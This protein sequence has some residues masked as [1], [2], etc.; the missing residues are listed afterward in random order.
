MIDATVGG[1]VWVRRRNGSWWP[2]RVLS[3]DE[4][5]EGC[6]G[7]PRRSGTPV[8]LLGR[9]DASVDWYNLEKSIRIKAFR[10]GEFDECIEKA[11]VTAP[12]SCKKSVKYAHREDAI[13][14][15][16]ELEKSRLSKDNNSSTTSQIEK[17]ENLS[18]KLSG[19]DS[20]SISPQELS[21][22]AASPDNSLDCSRRQTPNDS[23]DD[24]TEGA[25]K[26]MRGLEDLGIGRA[27]SSFKKKRTQVVH[28]HNSLKKKSR[29]RRRQLNKV[30]KKPAMVTVPVICE[31]LKGLNEPGF[32]NNKVSHSTNDVMNI[33]ND[34]NN[35]IRKDNENSSNS[36]LL[37]NGCSSGRLF[38]V[39][40]IPEENHTAGSSPGLV[41]EMGQVGSGPPSSH[42]SLAETVSVG[43]NEFQESGSIISGANINHRMDNSTSE[44]QNK[45]KRNSRNKI[46]TKT[47]QSFLDPDDELREVNNTVDLTYPQRSMP[48]RQS[49]FTG[50]RKY[51]LACK[52]IDTG[53]LFDVEIE[54]KVGHFPQHLPYISLLSMFTGQSVTGHSLK[55][56]IL[57]DT[58]SDLQ[59]NSSACLNSSCEVGGVNKDIEMV[60]EASLKPRKNRLLSNKKIRRLSSLTSTKKPSETGTLKSP[61]FAC[62]PLKSVFGRI[63]AALG[64]SSADVVCTP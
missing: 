28:I 16:L 19:L 44:W 38:D 49:C 3:P 1:L 27:I 20:I 43:P 22:T 25:M 18:D 5:E 50:N 17:N 10:C 31:E 62:V 42:S 29:C 35:C 26:R 45:G 40:Y 64:I 34:A 33:D 37:E 24:G 21:R 39:P 12:T 52:K 57:N 41:P 59:L 48:I 11:K 23:E 60:P 30:L 53:A 47:L 15:A 46:K 58:V 9:E 4:V 61:D 32:S 14:H 6:L 55:V 13:R 7:L 8:K 51:Q 2:G 36:E 56:E 54:V 63:H